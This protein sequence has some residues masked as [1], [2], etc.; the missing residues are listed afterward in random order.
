M[1]SGL[2]FPGQMKQK[3]EKKRHMIAPVHSE[4][5]SPKKQTTVE[6]SGENPAWSHDALPLWSLLHVLPGQYNILNDSPK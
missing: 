2:T 1:L 3:Y 5:Y 6:N 4:Q